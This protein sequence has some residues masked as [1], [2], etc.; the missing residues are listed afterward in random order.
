MHDRQLHPGQDAVSRRSANMT[1]DKLD[2]ALSNLER[3]MGIHSAARSAAAAHPVHREEDIAAIRARQEALARREEPAPRYQP[4]PPPPAM[5]FDVS[6]LRAELG[7]L[8]EELNREM[9]STIAAQF[10]DIRNDLRALDRP[11][12]TVSAADL[13]DGFSRVTREL[14]LVASRVENSD[15]GALRA[16]VE[17]LKNH[18]SALARE[19]TLR[20]MADRWAVIEREIG[21]L[22]Q[23]LGTREDLNVILDRIA[24]LGGALR[25]LPGSD[26]MNAMEHQMRQLAEAVESLAGQSASLAP[27]HLGSIEERLDEITRA[28]VSVSVSAPPE[29]DTA[30]F[31]R[32]EAR[33]ATLARQFEEGAAPQG[34]GVEDR[35]VEIADRLESLHQSTAAGAAQ[36]Q[37]IAAV[38]D[39]LD[40]LTRRLDEARGSADLPA[41]MVESIEA[42]FA[43]IAQR[44]DTHHQSA[45]EKGRHMFQSL[46]QRMED[47]ARRIEENEREPA[48]A[49]TFDHMERRI[50]EIAQ[51]LTAGDGLSVAGSAQPDMRGFENLE[52]QIE[53]LS[54]KLSSVALPTA[55]NGPLADLAPRL[56]AISDQLAMGREDMIVAAREAAEEV[57]SKFSTGASTEQKQMLGQL[58]GDLRALEDLARN[59]DDRNSRTFE[60]IHD[61]LVKVADRIAGLE[62]SLQ[63][64]GAAA[65]QAQAPAFDPAPAPQSP[66]AAS[67][68]AAPKTAAPAPHDLGRSY[69]PAYPPAPETD[70]GIMAHVDDA[71]PVDFA[72]G[73]E[74]FPTQRPGRV[75]RQGLG[76]A[77]AAAMAARAALKDAL[78]EDEDDAEDDAP[79]ADAGKKSLLR[80]LRGKMRRGGKDKAAK[81]KDKK[82]A[83]QA[84]AGPMRREPVAYQAPHADADG[85]LAPAAGGVRPEAS[86]LSDEP[87][88]PGAGGADLAEIMRRVRA[89]R[90]GPEGERAAVEAVDETGKSDFIAAARRAARAAAD[91]VSHADKA[92]GPDAAAKTGLGGVFAARRRPLMVAAAAILLALLAFPLGR[93]Y[94]LDRGGVPAEVADISTDDVTVTDAEP[95]PADVDAGAETGTDAGTEAEPAARAMRIV[96]TS[97]SASML[98]TAENAMTA[99][100]SGMTAGQSFEPTD[101]DMVASFDEPTL[102]EPAMEESFSEG[103]YAPVTLADIPGEIGPI[104]LREAAVAGDA[105]AL[106]VIGDRLMGDGPGA[107]NSDMAAAATWYE[108]SAEHG[109]APAQYRIGN[110]YEKGLGVERDI[111]AAKRWYELAAEQGNVSAMHNLAVLYATDID[112]DRDM[113]EAARWFVEAAERGVKDSQVNL[114]ILS[115]RGEGVQQDLAESYKWLS[116]AAQAG[117]KDAA[118]KRDEVAGYMRPDQLKTAEAAVEL[119][120]VRQVDV[121]ANTMNVPDVWTTGKEMTAAAPMSNDDMRKAVRNIQAILNNNGYDAGPADGIMGARTREAIISFQ[122]DNGM[123]PTGEVDRALVDKLLE[124][125][126]QS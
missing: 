71:P 25:G 95:A 19:D 58:A 48:E 16:E 120:K 49:P 68:P 6:A 10:A 5:G 99:S 35:L 119:W 14:G 1:L 51:M 34:G 72:A 37:A 43:E 125:N 81:A 17:D 93:G 8:R 73:E 59:S 30:P 103:G 107:P 32:I 52:A 36:N 85:P 122:T 12:E 79:Q 28:I 98:P 9:S 65:P 83:P 45:E 89:A 116:L 126:Q 42:R 117:D 11:G 57:V 50:E 26:S 77:E 53:A 3:R 21:A 39:R 121:A 2:E 118:A 69:S 29:M 7:G 75:I 31:E 91:D 76:P 87:I 18:V 97:P 96:D 110:A 100:A 114:G 74:P 60:A 56:T 55:D 106:F 111:A 105:K 23:T 109:Y 115:A 94:I 24:D 46:D 22:P 90:G 92:T 104:A 108:R 70:A 66:P 86:T 15:M 88:E 62:A 67:K 38:A 124:V 44:L 123:V 40:E 33:L 78:D 112:G 101:G 54:Q 20:D 84:A 41:G 82:K 4:A 27:G 64:A 13:A 63:P 47:L 113:A 102:D 61:T 80:G